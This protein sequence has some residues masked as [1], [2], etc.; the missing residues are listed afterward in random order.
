M[1]GSNFVCGCLTER[2]ATTVG[3]D[4]AMAIRGNV[5]DAVRRETLAFPTR[6][7]LV[8]LHLHNARDESM[9]IERTRFIGS[10]MGSP[11]RGLYSRYSP[12]TRIYD[13]VG[14]NG[15]G[16]SKFI[17]GVCRSPL[18][19]EYRKRGSHTLHYVPLGLSYTAV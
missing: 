4:G 1:R 10:P 11:A 3:R 14:F 19:T 9:R 2:L 8:S 16:H 7:A 5:I 17:R 6:A 13:S 12:K 15:G 18:E